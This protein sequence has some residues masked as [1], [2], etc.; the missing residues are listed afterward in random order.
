MDCQHVEAVSDP[1]QWE[2]LGHLA[3][4]E[5]ASRLDLGAGC[6]PSW[7]RLALPHRMFQGEGH[8][9][10]TLPTGRTTLQS[11]QGPITLPSV[12]GLFYFQKLLFSPPNPPRLPRS[13]FS[14]FLSF[15]HLCI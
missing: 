7:A 14:S 4:W 15:E 9:D 13:L 10:L 11:H 1:K 8:A 2:A 5:G 6:A 3:G 12:T